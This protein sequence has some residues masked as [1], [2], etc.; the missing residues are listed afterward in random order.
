MTFLHQ[1]KESEVLDTPILLFDFQ[2]RDGGMLRWST[3]AT[4]FNGAAYSARVLK[5]DGF[6]MRFA[7]DGI[8]EAGGRVQVTL[9][10]ADSMFS[11]MQVASTWKGG[12]LTVRFV[13]FDLASGA[14]T[15]DSRVL[16]RGICNGLDYA[17]E[18]SMQVSFHNRQAIQ[19]ITLP[20]VRIQ[21]RCPWQFP[22]TSEEREMAVSGGERSGYSHL[23][24]CG[25]SP[26]K[27]GGV[28]SVGPAG[29]YTTCDRT[30][31]N[32]EQRGMFSADSL[33]RPTGRFAGCEGLEAQ[34]GDAAAKT[35]GRLVPV[36]YGTCW[37][38]PPV[39][40]AKDSGSLQHYQIVLGHGPLQGV[41]KVLANRFEI[42]EYHPSLSAEA[43]GW[44][45]VVSLGERN[46]AF[47]SDLQDSE[48]VLPTGPYGSIAYLHVALPASVHSGKIMPRF[49]ALVDGG[50]LPRY[51]MDGTS[52]GRTFSK[53]PAWV[54]LD[55]LHRIGWQ[56]TDIDLPSFAQMAGFCDALVE[57]T[58]PD[59]E[60]VYVP[61]YRCNLALQEQ[62]SVSEVLRGIHLST[63]LYVRY[64]QDGR[65]S[66]ACEHSLAV[67]SPTIPVGSN[68]PSPI[69]GGWPAYEFGDGTY[70]FS[71]IARRDNG[72]PS[73]RVWSRSGADTPNRATLEFA[74]EFNRYQRDS[75]TLADGEDLL[76]IGQEIPVVSKALG[77][78]N[79]SQ[80]HRALSKHLF[81]ST[82]G[83]LYVEFDTSV[84][85][86]C[87]SPGDIITVT[88]LHNGFDRTPFRIIRITPG[89]NC[90]VI[91]IVGQLHDDAWYA[92]QGGEMRVSAAQAM[93]IAASP[94]PILGSIVEST[95]ETSFALS[96]YSAMEHD[97]G[98]TALL[99][100][101]YLRPSRT[102][103]AGASVA[104]LAL[105]PEVFPSG[106]SLPAGQQYYYG[107]TWV[108]GSGKESS[109]S[110]L[111]RALLG[112]GASTYRVVL[113]GLTF[114]A[115]ATAFHVYRGRN[116]YQML[117]I[118]GNL[119]LSGSFEDPGYSWQPFVPPDDRFDHANFYWRFE[120]LPPTSA[121][122][123]GSTT[124]GS[125][126]LNLSAG[127]CEGKVVRIVAGKGQGQ[128]RII[129]SNTA[130]TI[131]VASRFLIIPDATSL[132]CVAESS[133]NFGAST[134]TDI[135]DFEVP[136]RP[137]AWIQIIGRAAS[138]SGEE[139]D[140]GLSPLTRWALNGAAGQAM[141]TAPPPMP[142]FGLSYSGRGNADLVGVGFAALEN[143][144][145]INSGELLLH[146]WNELGNPCPYTLSAALDSTSEVLDCAPAMTIAAGTL[147]QVDSEVMAV[148]QV[149]NSG[150]RLEVQRAAF[151]SSGAAHSL[152]SNVYPL[153]RHTTVVPF[154]SSFFGSPASGTYHYSIHLPNAR[155][156]AAEFSVTNSRGVSP[157]RQQAFTASTGG[158]L[159]THS[160]GQ[161]TVMVSG[162]LSLQTAAAPPL[163]IDESRS[164]R[165]VYAVIAEAPSG[166]P[167]EILL[168]QNGAPYVSLTIPAGSTTSNAVSGVNL[169]PLT[170]QSILTVDIIAVPAESLDTPGR[171]LTVLVRV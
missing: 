154:S 135:V 169:P 162:Y 24:A 171:D 5:H 164:V 22:A 144:N 84:K 115:N 14:A 103:A 40:F 3:H 156:A 125:S 4:V 136:N 18:S 129:Q 31:A 63:G 39:V 51:D 33:S 74:D 59:G 76:A 15:T 131:T 123:Y 78:P 91:H 163:V 97:G 148:T 93:M 117:R 130:T 155:I 21:S 112:T 167:I 77:I 158:G 60:L 153:S 138:G 6:D 41:L 86:I 48:G 147:I 64:L 45:R 58:T 151:G 95:G 65:L 90:A 85:G 99:K 106:G 98:E 104:K 168:R 139:S 61:R 10:N 73:I 150:T 12:E 132:F 44:Y 49:E 72:E 71:G 107:I 87:L 83:N 105:Q 9:A 50:L 119:A 128:E 141:D 108:D 36:V 52:L 35:G 43:T 67:Q 42:P 23:H 92:E 111:S 110:A 124:V 26:D 143:T 160:G 2:P 75:L 116:P 101:E 165:D 11:P 96:E 47:D 122:I 166:G 170:G 118:A 94:R 140:A 1:I 121:T 27:S 109:V 46:G 56:S 126:G 157:T 80:A 68:S 159:R 145:S 89:L 28:G 152:N 55:L 70:G 54:L 69:N 120:W 88:Y 142:Y 37:V 16:F 79:Y 137:G 102:D 100:V 53:N 82:R 25:Y 20:A 38:S 19:R 81:K 114:P 113:T 17:T 34:F 57:T 32:C 146:Y 127:E 7:A 62:R 133:W 161:Y 13:F 30:R 66:L 134:S 149:L 8:S 29:P